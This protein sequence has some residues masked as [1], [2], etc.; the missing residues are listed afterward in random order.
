VAT[1]SEVRPLGAA[2]RAEIVYQ[3]IA[4]GTRAVTVDQLAART[5]LESKR[6]RGAVKRLVS[7]GR[8]DKVCIAGPDGDSKGYVVGP[9]ALWQASRRK[10]L[11]VFRGVRKGEGS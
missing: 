11:L 3:E 1:A 6:V 8:V 10:P 2:D 7:E 5:G 4:G 9:V